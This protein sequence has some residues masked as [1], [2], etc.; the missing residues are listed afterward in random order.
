MHL[1][2]TKKLIHLANVFCRGSENVISECA[3]Y[4]NTLSAGIN[5]MEEVDVAGV[6]CLPAAVV[7]PSNTAPA[8]SSPGPQVV[9]QQS[10]CHYGAH[11]PSAPDLGK[12]RR[13]YYYAEG[14]GIR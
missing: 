3:S 7:Q 9:A 8:L 10:S 1:F 4:T 14:G 5:M 13:H 6:V 2:C 12:V 11:I